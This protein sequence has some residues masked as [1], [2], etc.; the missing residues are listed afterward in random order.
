MPKS[1]QW[2]IGRL[3]LWVFVAALIASHLANFYQRQIVGFT[4]FSLDGS[5]VIQWIT[6][7]DPSAK[8]HGGGEG[9]SSSGDSVDSDLDYMFTSKNATSKQ[10]LEHLK[11]KIQK[12]LTDQ[13]WSIHGWGEGN[14][15]FDFHAYNGDTYF[16]IYGWLVPNT[17]D[18][19]ARQLEERG[20]SVTTI[21]ILR[22]GYLKR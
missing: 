8:S 2:S 16:R 14:D 5:D 6:E 19:Y 17:E 21:K 10:I 20:E 3:F 9:S 1:S 18:S 13:N 11:S 7:L 15:S 12:Q 22:V 4:D